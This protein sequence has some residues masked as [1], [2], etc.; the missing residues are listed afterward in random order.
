MKYEIMLGAA[1]FLSAARR[2]ELR[3][4]FYGAENLY[5]AG[6]KELKAYGKLSEEEME[7]WM[8]WKKKTEPERL[9]EELEEKGIRFL[10]HFAEDFPPLLSKIEYPPYALYCIGTLPVEERRVGI[11]GARNCTAYGRAVT[12][13]LAGALAG[14]GIAV[15]SGMARGI[16]G[17]A[18]RGALKKNGRTVAVLGCGPDVIYPKENDDI[19]REIRES[20]CIVS[21]YLPGTDPRPEFFP[22]RNRIISGLS[23]FLIVTEARKKSGSLITAREA[24]DQGKDVYAVPG[25]TKDPLSEGTNRLIADGAR[26]ILGEEDFIRDLAELYPGKLSLAMSGSNNFKLEKEERLV[27]SCLDFYPVG[28]ERIVNGSGLSI[29]DTVSALV[30]LADKGLAKEI[31]INQ[32]IKIK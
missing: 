22:Q 20:G 24:L 23:D 9:Q 29:M 10:P 3:S 11:V 26:M 7:H 27:Y 12:T 17:V 4:A 18:H 8:A 14:A 25:R 13:E 6:I 32:Y 15:V 19:Y 31:Y 30:S 5:R 2:R 21:E 28:L 1:V 16:D